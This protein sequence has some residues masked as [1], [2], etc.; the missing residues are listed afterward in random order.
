MAE[1]LRTT[2]YNDGTPISLV[3]DGT[4]WDTLTTPAYCYYDTTGMN[5]A[6]YTQDTFGALYN[7]YVVA[8]TSSLNVCPEGWHVPTDAEW[9]TL[10]TYL[11]DNSV[12]GG[13]MKETGTF[14]WNS[15]NVGATNE[16]DFSG[17]P[18]GLRV[19]SGTF[20]YIGNF[21]YW[22]SSTE[23]NTSDAWSRY[24]VYNNVNAGSNYYPKSSGFSVRCLRD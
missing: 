9:T 14:H 6:T 1:N 13:K 17:L 15:P 7:Y 3:T 21:G 22:W 19:Y 18:G 20:N 2:K 5:Y 11:G 23:N 24:L 12:A 10:T 16:T 4:A 8:D